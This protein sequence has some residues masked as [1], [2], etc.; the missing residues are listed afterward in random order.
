MSE[1]DYYQTLQLN[2]TATIDDVKKAFRRLSLK[3]HPTKNPSEITVCSDQ[4][5]QI[6]E[7]YEVLSD[8]H[9]SAIYNKFGPKVLAKGLENGDGNAYPGYKYQQNAFEIFEKFYSEYLPYHEIFDDTGKMLYGSCFSS[10]HKERNVEK[11]QDVKI[12]LECSIDELYNGCTKEITYEGRTRLVEIQPGY[13]NGHQII[14]E[15]EC[16][17]GYKEEFRRIIVTVK[18]TSHEKYSRQGDDLVYKHDIS[19]VDAL[20]SSPCKFKT[21]DGRTLNISIDEVITPKTVKVVE[22]EGMP[23]FDEDQEKSSVHNSSRGRLFV[24]FNILFPSE[25]KAKSQLQVSKI[26]NP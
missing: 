16:G 22:E 12:T 15:E 5:H 3:Y 13:Q 4:F 26:L 11:L 17:K 2:R 24:T 6:C 14:I 23:V 21:L 19:L 1:L 8:K 18:Q 9:L 25:L 10:I 20:N 7:A